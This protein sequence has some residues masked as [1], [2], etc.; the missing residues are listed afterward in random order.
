MQEL[1]TL[2]LLSGVQQPVASAPVAV[3]PT[4]PVK[5]ATSTHKG[6][7][8]KPEPVK[9]GQPEERANEAA[10]EAILVRIEA[11][12]ERA[13]HLTGD[14]LEAAKD[15][16][17]GEKDAFEK[18]GRVTSGAKAEALKG[19]LKKAFLTITRMGEASAEPTPVDGNDGRSKLGDLPTMQALVDKGG[20][21]EKNGNVVH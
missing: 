11:L 14:D 7:D 2:Q 1:G 6:G 4:Q 9:K 18:I 19:R 3:A 20:G 16:A 17:R 5:A 8:R 10:K 13:S 12:A 21:E 15:K